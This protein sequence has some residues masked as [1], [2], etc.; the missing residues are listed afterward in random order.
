MDH[1]RLAED[2]RRG[3]RQI[4]TLSEVV[5]SISSELDLEPLL[6]RIVAASVELLRAYGGAIGLAQPNG[7]AIASPRRSTSRRSRAH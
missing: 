2:M 4:V 1:A 5:E 3:A 7:D 6:H